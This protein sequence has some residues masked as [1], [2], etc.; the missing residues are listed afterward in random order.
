MLLFISTLTQAALVGRLETLPGSGVYQA[1]YDTVLDITWLA[2]ANLAVTNTFGV[3]GI[4]A[5]GTMNWNT[6]NS[7]IAA[8]NTDGGTGYL[9]YNDWRLPKVSPIDGLAF[10]YSLAYNGTTDIGYNISAPGT[11]YAGATGSE[12]AYMYYNNLSLAGYFNTSGVETGCSGSPP[13]CLTNTG[14]FFESA[15]Q[16]LLV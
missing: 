14:P 1:Y 8:M 2:N 13:Y 4:N 9:G 7:W 3:A 15:E 12:M 16:R 5:D 6:A 10:D 11:V